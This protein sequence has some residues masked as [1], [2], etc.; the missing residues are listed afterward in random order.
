MTQPLRYYSIGEVSELIGE[1]VSLVRYWSNTFPK[2]FKLPRSPKGNRRYTAGDIEKLKRIQYL[3][4]VDGL[5]LAGVAKALE[6]ENPKKKKVEK[7][8]QV[9]ESLK[10][11][12][13]RLVEVKKFL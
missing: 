7:D 10:D 9:L 12:R 8:V 4:N 5:T 6:E 2:Q 3:V 1:S 11:I 13:A